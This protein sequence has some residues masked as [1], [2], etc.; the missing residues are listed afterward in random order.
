ML[1]AP[2]SR[3][4]A[5]DS[6][7]SAL[8][9][10]A[11][12]APASQAVGSRAHATSSVRLQS[13][14]SNSAKSIQVRERLSI[15]ARRE[16]IK[17]PRIAVT[18]PRAVVLARGLDGSTRA[19]SKPSRRIGREPF[20]PDRSAVGPFPGHRPRSLLAPL[21]AKHPAVTGVYETR[22]S[23]ASR[24]CD[25]RHPHHWCAG[26]VAD[27]IAKWDDGGYVCR[28]PRV[29]NPLPSSL[30]ADSAS[31][32]RADEHIPLARGRRIDR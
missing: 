4:S 31:A 16:I 25:G 29:Q 6:K 24:A 2:R 8:V 27:E 13:E 12:D 3:S 21:A 22:S 17:S 23:L 14:R 10:A 20:L 7:C 1:P 15:D 19:S 32:A 30:C 9:V 11:L 26:A 18:R 28:L 5:G